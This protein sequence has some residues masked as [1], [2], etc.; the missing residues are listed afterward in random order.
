MAERSWD[1]IDEMV[2]RAA[3]AKLNGRMLLFCIF[4][5]CMRWFAF[6]FAV[7]NAELMSVVPAST[8]LNAALNSLAAI[9]S[10]GAIC[11]RNDG[12]I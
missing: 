5:C 11:G 7:F 4:S 10:N 2:K 6:S 12:G 3:P 9:E 8:S 1:N